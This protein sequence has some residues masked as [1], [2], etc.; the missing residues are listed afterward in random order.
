MSLDSKRIVCTGC[1]YKT[2][3][4]YVPMELYYCL[5]DGMIVPGKRRRGWCHECDGYGDIESLAVNE[6]ERVLM[7]RLEDLTALNATVERL[8]CHWW[9]HF[10]RAELEA[11]I[12]ERQ[13]IQSEIRGL[14][15]ILPL[16]KARQSGPR[17]LRCGSG[18]TQPV[19]FDP[20]SGLSYDFRHDCG[21]QLREV[22]REEDPDPIRF[23]FRMSTYWLDTEGRIIGTGDQPPAR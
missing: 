7:R 21:G 8:N 14:Q 3:E 18:R 23:M 16:L 12:L 2:R 5:P 9:R 10:H 13:E 15:A 20:I 1:D 11:A 19:T 17:C 22:P 6:M 4:R